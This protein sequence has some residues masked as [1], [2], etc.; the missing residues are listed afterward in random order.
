[1]EQMDLSWLLLPWVKQQMS[2][3]GLLPREGFHPRVG[4][5]APS[6][7]L[8]PWEPGLRSAVGRGYLFQ[9]CPRDNRVS[10]CL[11]S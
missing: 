9:L 11:T 10:S 5:S 3:V 8:L 1:M 6:P 7:Q 4:A 2:R